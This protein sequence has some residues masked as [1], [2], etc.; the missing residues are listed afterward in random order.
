MPAAERTKAKAFSQGRRESAINCTTCQVHV[1]CQSDRQ[2]DVKG[3]VTGRTDKEPFYLPPLLLE[4]R[5]EAVFIA[6]GW[7]NFKLVIKRNT[8]DLVF[9]AI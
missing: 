5:M 6:T 1:H 7:T 9:N 8:L 2:A 4:H 3:S